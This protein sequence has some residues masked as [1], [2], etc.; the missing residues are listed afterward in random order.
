MQLLV[1][2]KKRR[3]GIVCRKIHLDLL[4]GGHDNHVLHHTRRC[5]AGEL[6]QLEV[7]P[8][9]MNRVR[10][11]TLVVEAEAVPL[12]GTHS[13]GISLWKDFPLMVQ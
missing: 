7:M 3:T 10:F 9:Q 2:V 5:F 4:L 11:I 12:I 1:A 13:N 8:M 6:R